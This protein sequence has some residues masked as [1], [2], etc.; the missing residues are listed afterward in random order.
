MSEKEQ[1]ERLHAAL[2][3]LLAYIEIDYD[4]REMN[5]GLDCACEF[6]RTVLKD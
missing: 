4:G 2:D 1:I 3:K 6:A 5:H